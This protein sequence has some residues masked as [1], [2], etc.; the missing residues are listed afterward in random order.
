MLNIL[1]KKQEMA[2]KLKPSEDAMKAEAT[3]IY[4]K[5]GPKTKAGIPEPLYENGVEGINKGN[6]E[7]ERIYGQVK[8]VRNK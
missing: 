6:N 5:V 2:S 3:K 4:N 8:K 7:W 1:K